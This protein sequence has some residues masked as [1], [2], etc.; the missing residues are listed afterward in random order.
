MISSRYI[1]LCILNLFTLA[2]ITEG[3]VERIE[4]EHA[5]TLR[6]RGNVREL[7]G[8]VQIRRGATLITSKK[9]L[10]DAKAG[11]VVLTGDV[12]LD[13]PGQ[14]IRAERMTYN[15][16]TG[17]FEASANVDML[18]ADSM[19]IRCDKANYVELTGTVDLFGDIIID[20]LSDGARITGRH[21]RWNQIK[22]SGIIDWEPVYMLPDETGDP[23]DTLVITSDKLVFNRTSRVAVFTGDVDLMQ[24]EIHAVADSLRHLPDSSITILSGNPV[25]WRGDDEL[26]GKR[27]ELHYEGRTLSKTFVQD[28]AV[29]LSKPEEND[30]LRNYLSGITLT[31]TTIDDSTRVIVVKGDAKGEYHVWDSDT[32]Y[33]GVNISA[34]DVI[35]LTLISDKVTSIVL[36]GRANGAFYPPDDLPE[37]IGYHESLAT[38]RNR[39]GVNVRR[40]F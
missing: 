2:A 20:N 6:S 1:A 23:P 35:E 27:I 17:D 3:K 40:D 16:L 8:H 18:H 32:V 28:D 39:S 33:Q 15:E 24:V 25:I 4:L 7:I 13:E 29:A 34:A 9:A 5:D 11:R 30:S 36:S 21:G 26:T 19:R 22:D 12:L 10:Y 38:D 14:K 37:G 31:M